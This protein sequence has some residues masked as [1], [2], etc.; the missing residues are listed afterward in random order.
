MRWPSSEHVVKTQD[1]YKRLNPVV[2]VSVCLSLCVCVCLV[3]TLKGVQVGFE[4][5]GAGVGEVGGSVEV[6][7][8]QDLHI[9]DSGRMELQQ[10]LNPRRLVL[11]ALPRHKQEVVIHCGYRRYANLKSV[12]VDVDTSISQHL[13]QAQT[14]M[15]KLVNHIY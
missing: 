14:N 1:F 9:S 12:S 13:P 5:Q 2:C 7:S 10:V 4:A 6:Q 8:R 11:G 15:F 3:V